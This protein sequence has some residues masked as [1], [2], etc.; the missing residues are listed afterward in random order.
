MIVA[1][2]LPGITSHFRARK[3]E[4]YE[5][6]PTVLVGFALYMEPDLFETATAYRSVAAW[7]AEEWWAIAFLA[8]TAM[9]LFALIING[10]F[11]TF[12][13][14][15]LIRLIASVFAAA[16]WL[17]LFTGFFVEWLGSGR[18]TFLC[19]ML[20]HR[21]LVEAMNAF[22]AS[23]DMGQQGQGHAA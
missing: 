15:P 14:A 1:R 5:I 7:M 10:T 20:S 3:S 13:Y 19:I 17:Q 23:R 4:W 6:W 18:A 22:W 16:F 11:K 8:V 12:T 9:R 21:I 2:I